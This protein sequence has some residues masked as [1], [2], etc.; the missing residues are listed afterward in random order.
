[1]KIRKEMLER[2]KRVKRVR[3]KICMVTK[4]MMKKS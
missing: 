4:L 2:V 3:V 1:M